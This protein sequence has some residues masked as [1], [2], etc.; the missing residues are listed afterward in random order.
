MLGARLPE[1]Q[2]Q[3][4]P[5]F[6]EDSRQDYIDTNEFKQRL[7]DAKWKWYKDKVVGSL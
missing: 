4:T 1:L 3:I 5:V 7:F 2:N 6:D